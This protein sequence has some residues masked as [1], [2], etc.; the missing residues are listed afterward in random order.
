M[1]SNFLFLSDLLLLISFSKRRNPKGIKEIVAPYEAD[2]ETFYSQGR[3]PRTSLHCLTRH[4]KGLSKSLRSYCRGSSCGISVGATWKV[5]IG[6]MKV[7]FS[8]SK[9]SQ[10][11]SVPASPEERALVCPG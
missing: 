8:K 9:E 4:R 5:S 1:E 2:N 11:G 10:L 6:R 3:I 7:L